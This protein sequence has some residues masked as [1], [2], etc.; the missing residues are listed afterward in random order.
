MVKI[1]P[2]LAAAVL[3]GA[4]I[5]ARGAENARSAVSQHSTI[6]QHDAAKRA[7]FE[8]AVGDILDGRVQ[9]DASDASRR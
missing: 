9:P 6:D 1:L 5:E 4:S 2:F 3:F 7:W 8:R